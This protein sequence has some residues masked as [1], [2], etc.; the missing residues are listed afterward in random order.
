MLVN[1]ERV[2]GH[3]LSEY[4]HWDF[5]AKVGMGYFDGNATKYISRWRKKGGLQD[6][7]KALHY[8]DKY[9]EIFNKDEYKPV[10]RIDSIAIRAEVDKFSQANALSPVEQMAI[11]QLAAWEGVSDLWV[12]R[13]LIQSLID[14]VESKPVPVSDS[15]KHANRAKD[16]T[17]W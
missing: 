17:G 4:L 15:N 2:P 5:V 11:L 3:Y 8:V 12:A 9:I 10:L 14:D 6:L 16:P 1:D 7:Q 13:G